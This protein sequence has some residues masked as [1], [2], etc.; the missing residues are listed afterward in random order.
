LDEKESLMD[1][2]NAIPSSGQ[3]LNSRE[4]TVLATDAISRAESASLSI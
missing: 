1:L 3:A 4:D 2:Q